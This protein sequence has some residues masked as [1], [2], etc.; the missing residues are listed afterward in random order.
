MN[1]LDHSLYLD[2]KMEAKSFH[3]KSLFPIQLT[4]K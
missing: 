4:Q 1:D 2:E 3:S